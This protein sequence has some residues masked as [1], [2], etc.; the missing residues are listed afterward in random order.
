MKKNESS[1]ESRLFPVVGMAA[2]AGGLIALEQFLS[3]VPVDCG[4]AFVVVQHLDPHREG[5]LVEL[6]RR[7]T[8]MPVDEVSDQMALAPDHVYVIPPGRDLRIEQGVLHLQDPPEPRG[9]RLPIDSF[10]KSNEF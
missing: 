7:R 9:L 10:F 6:L 3:H 1:A 2:S 4:M 5:M 8:P